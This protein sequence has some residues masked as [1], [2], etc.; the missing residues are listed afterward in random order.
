[1]H[2]AFMVVDNFLDNAEA[3]RAHALTLEYPAL[4]GQ[5]PGRNSLQRINVDG[6]TEAVST[7]VGEPLVPAQPPQS[8]AK[9]RITLGR[10][11]GRGKVHVDESHWSGILYLSRPENCSGGTEFF[12]HKATGLDQFPFSADDL[13]QHGFA[14]HAAAHRALIERDGTDDSAWKSLMM[15][16]M[17]FNRLVLLRP[18]LFHTAGSGFGDRLENG[19]L[20]Y[21]MFFN[22]PA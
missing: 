22:R 18:F 12:R 19:R 21:L 13:R 7:L 15:I 2:T 11:A 9:F 4:E 6:L 16:P 20:V 5:F 14:D 10:D 17:K 1:M 8:H 3:L